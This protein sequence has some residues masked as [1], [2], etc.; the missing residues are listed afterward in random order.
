MILDRSLRPRGSW[1]FESLNQKRL[2]RANE[3]MGKE[4]WEAEQ[5][6]LNIAVHEILQSD[7]LSPWAIS[8][9]IMDRTWRNRQVSSV[10]TLDGP[11]DVLRFGH[12]LLSKILK[13]EV[14]LR[15]KTQQ[16]LNHS[17]R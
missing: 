6:R 5:A 12:R 7:S 15:T 16:L 11:N 9:Y 4:G 13:L 14:V 1:R 10:Q 3:D 8:W 17:K 2:C